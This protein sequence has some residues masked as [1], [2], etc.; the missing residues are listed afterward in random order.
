MPDG[1][2]LSQVG[3]PQMN[4]DPTPDLADIMCPVLR[5][6]VKSG[7]LEMDED[8]TVDVNQLYD[9]MEF[10]GF[11]RNA[12]VLK[13][14]IGKTI[15]D[16]ESGRATLTNFTGT[17]LD[18]GSVSGAFR[19]DVKTKGTLFSN[20]A[21]ERIKSYSSNKASF[22]L[23]DAARA[24][25]AFHKSPLKWMKTSKEGIFSSTFEYALLV[26][27]FGRQSE[28]K[29]KFLLLSDIDRIWKES[30]F[31][32]YWEP[33]S[34]ATIG[35]LGF[36]AHT[37]SQAWR[38]L[39]IEVRQWPQT[40]KLPDKLTL[41]TIA[42]FS[43]YLVGASLW[44]IIHS[45]RSV[46]S[47]INVLISPLL[48][49][50]I[51]LIATVVINDYGLAQTKR[52][53][54]RS[55]WSS[56]KDNANN[57]IS[58]YSTWPALTDRS[59]NARTLSPEGYRTRVDPKKLISLFTRKQ[60][61]GKEKNEIKADRTSILFPFFARWLTDSFMRIDGNDR[62]KNTSNHELDLCQIYGLSEVESDALRSK[63][64]GKL[65]SRC[66]INV[67]GA[68][69]EAEGLERETDKIY[70]IKRPRFEEY[71]PLLFEPDDKSGSG[72]SYKG[73]LKVKEE[74][75]PLIKR[76]IQVSLGKQHP[77]HKDLES[78]INA[79]FKTLLSITGKSIDDPECIEKIKHMYAAGLERGN[80]SVGYTMFSTLFLREHNRIC[81][82]LIE[83]EG[84]YDDD[85][86]FHTARFI[87]TIV[88][89]KLIVIDY[90]KHV[91]GFSF[92][93]GFYPS[94][95][96]KL[97]KLNV[98]KIKKQ[99]FKPNWI[100]LE[101]NLLYRW[102][103]MVPDKFQLQDKEAP[104]YDF[105]LNNRALEQSGLAEAF[106]AAS[107]QRANKLTLHNTPHYLAEAERASL[108]MD[109]KFKLGSFNSYRSLF[110]LDES[111][112]LEDTFPQE[113]IDDIKEAYG[114]TED[115]GFDMDNIDYMVGIFGEK[116]AN[117]PFPLNLISKKR[118]FGDLM[119][120]MVAHDAFT[121]LYNNP[122]LSEET[123]NESVLTKTGL[124]I[125][126]STE[127]FEDLVVRNTS[128]GK[129]IA[130]FSMPD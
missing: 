121:H 40:I 109:K 21:V 25:N 36:L 76:H 58:H 50:V 1:N 60:E 52:P 89:L 94:R 66:L 102:H 19:D 83:K 51:A 123:F 72:L 49:N 85:K 3:N 9:F 70:Q 113:S 81:E 69:C 13:S 114:T 101:F 30:Q 65:R 71:L 38:R 23:K 108:E 17:M 130:K 45:V 67:D 61:N 59:F 77:T 75:Q 124:D 8:G 33:P 90:I 125:I 91:G 56:P 117:W 120:K 128:E 35:T 68:M 48:E 78:Y 96:A 103:S 126:N 119:Y 84:I 64:H 27:I 129:V 32:R 82:L 20:A 16:K 92:K 5:L 26:N 29:E 112:T 22:T 95:I 87:T 24:T 4:P 57:I 97:G 98:F 28:S 7:R 122:L 115:N 54:I 2:R 73:I 111:K 43:L 15:R 6:G 127:S 63:A 80:A 104:L 31:P 10:I 42:T 34:K 41:K 106:A 47:A 107:Q 100:S 62:R 11:N 39:D 110:G 118:L 88:Y 86:L 99:W 18:H 12:F 14:V 116:P 105:F 74:F 79:R 46:V 55:L 53:A 37:A 93:W 44:I